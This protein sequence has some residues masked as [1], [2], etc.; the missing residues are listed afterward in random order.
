MKY[1]AESDKVEKKERKKDSGLLQ[2]VLS[3]EFVLKLFQPRVLPYTIAVFIL[4]FTAIINDRSIKNKIKRYEQKEIEYKATL[5]HL[6]KNNHFIPYDQLIILQDKAKSWGFHRK[7]D[8]AYK[9]T[10][11][12]DTQTKKRERKK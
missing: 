2:Y 3:G 7:Q 6:R 8:G 10:I 11:Q 12:E 9:I 5:N 4:T 1:I